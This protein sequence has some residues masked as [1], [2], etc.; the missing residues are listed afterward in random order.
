[1]S[2]DNLTRAVEAAGKARVVRLG[3]ALED[4]KAIVDGYRSQWPAETYFDFNKLERITTFKIDGRDVP[5]CSLNGQTVNMAEF[6]ETLPRMLSV[7]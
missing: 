2:I 1:M 5:L 4:F 7:N 6:Y 3:A